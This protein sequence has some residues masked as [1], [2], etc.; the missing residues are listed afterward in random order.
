MESS[1]EVL[2]DYPF[3]RNCVSPKRGQLSKTA[4]TTTTDKFEVFIRQD[5]IL[6][7]TERE[8]AVGQGEIVLPL[9]AAVKCLRGSPKHAPLTVIRTCQ[10]EG[11]EESEVHCGYFCASLFVLH[12]ARGEKKYRLFFQIFRWLYKSDFILENKQCEV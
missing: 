7:L 6:A 9:K 11:K 12:T 1:L 5:Q 2:P 4:R 8:K 3:R 10:L